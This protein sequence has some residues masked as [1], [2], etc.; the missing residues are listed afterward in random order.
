M[1]NQLD[2][3]ESTKAPLYQRFGRFRNTTL[4]FIGA[5]RYDLVDRNGI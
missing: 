4:L 5:R 1:I 2:M 3:K